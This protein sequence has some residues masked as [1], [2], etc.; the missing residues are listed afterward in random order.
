MSGQYFRR[1][2]LTQLFA[3]DLF[4]SYD[5]GNNSTHGATLYDDSA[6]TSVYSGAR[7]LVYMLEGCI[8]KLA[9]LVL[10]I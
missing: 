1:T 6:R 8:E 10:I 3:N 9:E 2:P 7:L 4:P 5:D